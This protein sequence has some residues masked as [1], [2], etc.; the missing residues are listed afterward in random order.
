MDERL[1][2]HL[3]GPADMEVI[4]LS[5]PLSPGS[6]RFAAGVAATAVLAPAG[7]AGAATAPCA[8]ESLAQVFAGWGDRSW[9]FLAPHGSFEDGSA[10][11]ALTGGARVVD[12]SDP[13]GLGGPVD[14]K[15][16]VLP[17]GASATSAPFCI[18][19][20]SR[21]VRWVQQASSDGALAVEVIHAD[22]R[23]TVPGRMLEVV[24][25]HGEWQPSPEVKIP[26]HGTGATGNGYTSVALKL[27][28]L[29]STWSIDDLFVDPRQRR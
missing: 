15:S 9:Y 21:T 29:T 7:T 23:A 17:T 25:G 2:P 18:K 4:L 22:T 8:G 3:R 13:F 12:S 14:Q 11:W 1:G 6:R 27:T 26:M 10:G 5:H 20:D 19:R 24:R 28:A 16:L